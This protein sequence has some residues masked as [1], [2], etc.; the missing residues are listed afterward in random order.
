[1]EQATIDKP[2]KPSETS[3]PSVKQMEQF[4]RSQELF[5]PKGDQTIVVRHLW[6][7]NFR[8]NLYKTEKRCNSVIADN[9]MVNSWFVRVQLKS[10]KLTYEVVT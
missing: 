1:M 7:G 5:I 9:I 10:D 4:L 8:I 3:K 2:Q 6:A